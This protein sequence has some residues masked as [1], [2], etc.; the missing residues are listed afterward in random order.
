MSHEKP[1]LVRHALRALREPTVPFFVIGALLFVVHRAVAGD[2]RT[3]IVR[4][5]TRADVAR[6]FADREGRRPTA[7]ELNLA[8]L[9]WKRDEALYREALREGLDR[10]DATIRAVLADKL[11]MRAALEVPK[12][13]PSRAELERWLEAHRSRYE[14]PLRYEYELVTVDKAEPDAEPTLS[15]FERTLQLTPNAA[16]DRPITGGA[17]TRDELSARFGANLADRV[18]SMPR[19]RWLR[20]DAGRQ[21][22]FVRVNGTRGGLPPSDELHQRLAADW[23]HEKEQQAVESAVQQIVSRYRFEERP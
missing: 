19:E 15:R 1:V 8:L 10:D 20:V 3:I 21:W 9:E 18:T 5:S 11:R 13:E 12:R 2:P 4:E 22:H 17:L 7:K 23:S 16:L 6:H 14:T